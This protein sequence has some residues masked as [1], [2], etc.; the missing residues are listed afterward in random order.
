MHILEWFKNIEYT[1]VFIYLKNVELLQSLLM[2]SSHQVQGTI[3]P[4]PN[5]NPIMDAQVLGAALQGFGK[6]DLFYHLLLY[7][8]FCFT[9]F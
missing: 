3:F 2:D 5:F 9:Y 6:P 1:F 7:F 8:F 4:S